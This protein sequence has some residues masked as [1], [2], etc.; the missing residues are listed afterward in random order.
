MA[1]TDM[2]TLCPLDP[3]Y[4]GDT[5]CEGIAAISRVGRDCLRF[6]IFANR[7]RAD[8]MSERIVVAQ[9]IWPRDALQVAMYQAQMVLDGAPFLSAIAP[10]MTPS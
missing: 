2:N 1:S 6:T 3:N 4:V 10:P 7:E 5:M 8:G 9:L